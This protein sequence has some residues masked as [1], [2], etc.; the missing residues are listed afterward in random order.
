MEAPV[1]LKT[2]IWMNG[3]LEWFCYLGSE[4]VFLGGREVPFPLLEGDQ[5]TNRFGGSFRVLDGEIV[6]E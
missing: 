2:R 5:W 1:E 6:R 4:E 3:N